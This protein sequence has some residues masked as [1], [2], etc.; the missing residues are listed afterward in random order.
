MGQYNTDEERGNRRGGKVRWWGMAGKRITARQE[1]V[2]GSEMKA[3]QRM[4]KLG[5]DWYYD[6]YTPKTKMF[7]YFLSK[8]FFLLV[9]GQ[10]LIELQVCSTKTYKDSVLLTSTSKYDH[11]FW[12]NT[13]LLWCKTNR[14]TNFCHWIRDVSLLINIQIKPTWHLFCPNTC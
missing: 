9:K 12:G 3:G 6:I 11:W 7:V 14:F 4:W 8:C 13:N 2:V 1:G 10:N 5:V